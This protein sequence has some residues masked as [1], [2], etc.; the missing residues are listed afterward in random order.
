MS[1]ANFNSENWQSAGGLVQI[2][3]TGLT[4]YSGTVHMFDFLL[5]TWA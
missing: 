4:K 1:F 3:L 2:H 5:L